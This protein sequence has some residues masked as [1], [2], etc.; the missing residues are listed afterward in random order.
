MVEILAADFLS[1]MTRL[2]RRLVDFCLRKN[3]PKR[4]HKTDVLG[5]SDK[6]RQI[7]KKDDKKNKIKIG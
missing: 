1:W 5:K 4:V 7:K 3:R 2:L 6:Q